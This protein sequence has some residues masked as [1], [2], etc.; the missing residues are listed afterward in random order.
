VALV[1]VVNLHV[2]FETADAAVHAVDGVSFE[3]ERG[4]TLGL[5]GESGC[6][7]S[8]TALAMMGLLRSPPANVRT[9][10]VRVDGRDLLALDERALRRV[11]GREVSLI[12]QDPMTALHPL[13]TIGRQLTEVLEVH[14]GAKPREARRRAAEALAEVGLA[15]AESALDRHPHELSGGMLQRVMIA[16]ALLCRPKLLIADEPTT[17]LDVTLQAQILRLLR[18][19][20]ETHGTAILFITHD[21]GAVAEICDRIA[22]MYAGRFVETASTRELFELALHPYSLGL[23]NARPRLDGDAARALTPIP[24]RPPEP[25]RLPE[26]CAFT[27]RCA[28]AQLPCHDERPALKLW[29][30]AGE[31]PR[32]H[33]RRTACFEAHRTALAQGAEMALEAPPTPP[34]DPPEDTA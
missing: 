4:E 9:G 33:G 29:S 24:G 15:D 20:Q 16:M 1:E 11:R 17:A 26:G 5:V 10:E 21:L 13:L 8:V 6:G 34:A 18:R 25:S 32:L 27:P 30:R 22:V 3:I 23:L 31:A 19:L 14:E 12:Q 2:D 28:F 7:K